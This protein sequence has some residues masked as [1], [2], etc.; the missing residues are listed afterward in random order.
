MPKTR[1]VKNVRKNRSLKKKNNRNKSMRKKSL[2]KG[3]N[4]RKT[5]KRRMRGGMKV[6]ELRQENREKLRNIYRRTREL[7]GPRERLP[8]SYI[9]KPEV[10][11]S[12]FQA[13]TNPQHPIYEVN[14]FIKKTPNL[15]NEQMTSLQEMRNSYEKEW[16]EKHSEMED[17]NPSMIFNSADNFVKYLGPTYP[18]PAGA[19]KIREAMRKKIEGH[20]VLNSSPLTAVAPKQTK[21]SITLPHQQLVL[22][23]KTG[24]K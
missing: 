17:S 3:G 2:R 14:N 1:N 18:S 5:N 23:T 12:S 22:G 19:R 24:N 6:P 11:P 16:E 8:T 13:I 15:T 20:K 4:K 9:P 10:A 7:R 21:Q